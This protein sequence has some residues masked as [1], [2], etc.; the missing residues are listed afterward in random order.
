MSMVEFLTLWLITFGDRWVGG[1]EIRRHPMFAK[2]QSYG[3][4][5]IEA[6]WIK[7]MRGLGLGAQYQITQAGINFI[8]GE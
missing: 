3:I 6:G 8:Q 5:A 7:E 1:I 2:A 4:A